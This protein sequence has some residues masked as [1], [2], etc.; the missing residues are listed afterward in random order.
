MKTSKTSIRLERLRYLQGTVGLQVE[1][2]MKAIED[3]EVVE[4]VM[5][6]IVDCRHP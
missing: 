1:K 3:V 5:D 4:G 2:Y 6:V